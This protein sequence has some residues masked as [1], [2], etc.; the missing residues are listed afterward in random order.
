M[1]QKSFYMFPYSFDFNNNYIEADLT[2]MK[3]SI[4]YY[5]RICVSYNKLRAEIRLY[6]QNAPY[7]SVFKSRT[8]N[9]YNILNLI[10][11]DI[12]F[13]SQNIG[14]D[15]KKEIEIASIRDETDSTNI[16][17][18]G[19]VIFE[20][21]IY[22]KPTEYSFFINENQE[23]KDIEKNPKMQN[24]IKKIIQIVSIIQ[25]N[26]RKI[27][28]PINTLK[29]K[30]R[31]K[32]KN[33]F[34]SQCI[35]L[36]GRLKK[37][38]PILQ[39]KN[40][41]ELKAII[42]ELNLKIVN[43]TGM[44]NY[45]FFF[46]LH[47]NIIN[48][49]DLSDYIGITNE[50][51][52]ENLLIS[53]DL[54]TRQRHFNCFGSQMVKVTKTVSNTIFM[55]VIPSAVFEYNSY[56]NEKRIDLFENTIY[57]KIESYN[58][59][60]KCAI[61]PFIECLFN[62]ECIQNIP[63]N[64]LYCLLKNEKNIE[65]FLKNELELA[66]NYQL[67]AELRKVDVTLTESSLRYMSLKKVF[68]GLL[69][70]AVNEMINDLFT[71]SYNKESVIIFQNEFDYFEDDFDKLVAIADN[72]FEQKLEVKVGA[73]KGLKRKEEQG[74]SKTIIVKDEPETAEKNENITG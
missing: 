42:N 47:P 14:Y 7:T 13:F 17:K 19:I 66:L 41:E 60:E 73:A 57:E 59:P 8:K 4:A 62:D 55:F 54:V 38:C 27:F 67:F 53:H 33:F 44:V 45:A 9:K 63:I 56:D 52:Y 2:H 43:S 31:I 58:E 21:A 24:H 30:F 36:Q 48:S 50:V 32:A 18:K 16:F 5:R 6:L 64:L 34:N 70:W 22:T 40:H 37:Y 25:S 71:E 15:C 61:Y 51:F 69:I 26:M 46:D 65:I 1:L 74:T 10:V 35:I 11:I 68:L 72:F 29:N 3:S 23:K 49:S 12:I 28:E 20:D 39:I